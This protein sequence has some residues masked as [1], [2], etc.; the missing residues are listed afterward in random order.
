[1]FTHAQGSSDGSVGQ[2][3]GHDR[4]T[5][6]TGGLLVAVAAVAWVVVV[7]QSMAA[8]PDMGMSMSTPAQPD[9][10]MSAPM[11]AG[12]SWLSFAGAMA[13]LV[14]WGIMM[15]AMMLPSAT[16]M[17]ALY[18]AVRRN[19]SQ[20]G[21]AGIPTPLFALVYLALW[22]ATGI[23][24]YVASAALSAAAGTYPAIAGLLPYILALTLV[25]AGVY[26]F[27]SLK[28]ACLH[29]C[30]SPLS[31]LIGRWR[32]GYLG[33]FKMG[34]DHA[35]NCIGCCWGLMVVLVAAGA[36]SLPWVLSIAA[37]VFA[38]KIVPRGEWLAR[39]VGGLLI[40]LG[41]LVAAQ[42]SLAAAMRG[43]GM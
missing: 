14:A 19:L 20:T 31:F 9:M 39:I 36:M 7:L 43:S 5:W 18:G 11:T 37:V 3:L 25:V 32:G 33:T 35:I 42:P 24:V 29:V 13:F 23:P 10:G 27:S 41:L 17:I 2:N 8:Q 38:E 30:A 34:L 12:P 40:V 15:T 4:G 28:Q 1:M 22:L 16:P 6:L 26:Q 21:Q